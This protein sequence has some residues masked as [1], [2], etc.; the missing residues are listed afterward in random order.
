MLGGA[1]TRTRTVYC[2]SPTGQSVDNQS[3]CNSILPKPITQL[4]CSQQCG[5]KVAQATCSKTCGGGI[6]KSKDHRKY[7][8]F[9]FLFVV[10]LSFHCCYN[11]YI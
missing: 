2:V 10:F 4:S 8:F 9:I 5:W 1:G 6:G 3:R 11:A 7:I